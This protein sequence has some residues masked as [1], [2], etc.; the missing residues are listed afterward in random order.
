MLR[1]L[2]R[3]IPERFRW[4][5][6]ILLRPETVWPF[7]SFLLNHRYG[8]LYCPIQKVACTSLKYWMLGTL[9]GR[10]GE[11]GPGAIHPFMDRHYSL[12]SERPSDVA[13]VLSRY[14]RLAFVRNP[15][16]RVV[17]AYLDKFVTD[18]INWQNRA[19]VESTYEARGHSVDASETFT[20]HSMGQRFEL[21]VDPA[22]DYE[23]GITFREFVE[24]LCRTPDLELDVHWRP[25]YLFFGGLDFHTVGKMERLSRD[26][27]KFEQCMGIARTRL[28]HS[29]RVERS[30][31]TAGECLADVVSGRLGEL[32]RRPSAEE[33]YT[34]E[35]LERIRRRYAEDIC[36]FGYEC[37][38]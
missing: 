36:R 10:P 6:R 23:R 20:W 12:G 25:Q 5:G 32:D 16:E 3:L 22:V 9:G 15:W 31:G 30:G 27:R 24:Y 7:D 35:L 28:S 17:S 38:L 2:K 14:H 21:A 18:G 13:R 19:V 34:P 33:L 4:F 8:F 26:L 37:P 29:N 11:L 1:V